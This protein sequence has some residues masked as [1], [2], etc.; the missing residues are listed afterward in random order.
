MRILTHSTSFNGIGFAKTGGRHDLDAA[1]EM[2]G[3]ILGQVSGAVFSHPSQE[4]V[5]LAG[6]TIWND[7]VASAISRHGPE[8][9]IL[10]AGYAVAKGVGPI[11][12]KTGGVASVHDTA[13]KAVLVST[14]GGEP[15]GAVARRPVRLCRAAGFRG[16]ASCSGGRG[17]RSL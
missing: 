1:Y 2:M 15:R 12:M 6:D 4:T 16:P 8:V 3:Q 10:N 13:P 7:D 9:I 17:S 5:Y 14:G 11:L